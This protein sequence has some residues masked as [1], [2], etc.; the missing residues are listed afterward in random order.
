MKTEQLITKSGLAVEYIG[1][2]EGKQGETIV[3][4]KENG[5]L[6]IKDYSDYIEYINN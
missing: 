5:K 4:Y 2:V 1:I 3:V 6:S